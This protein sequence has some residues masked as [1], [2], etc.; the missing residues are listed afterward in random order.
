MLQ[1]IGV[2]PNESAFSKTMGALWSGSGSGSGSGSESGSGSV[3]ESGEP[4]PK[5]PMDK[6]AISQP[7]Q[8][9][10]NSKWKLEE[11]KEVYKKLV[12]LYTQK[13]SHLI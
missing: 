10:L 8:S 5:G 2:G 4:I 12:G 6:F 11:R 9:T 7:R 3:N 1:E 13:V